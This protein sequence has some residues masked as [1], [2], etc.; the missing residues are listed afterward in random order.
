MS[1]MYSDIMEFCVEHGISLSQD[2]IANAK[3]A[4]NEDSVEDGA[5][6]VISAAGS[7]PKGKD[8]SQVLND[9][10]YG[11]D[12]DIRAGSVDPEDILGAIDS[13]SNGVDEFDNDDDDLTKAN[14][15]A[16][17]DQEFYGLLYDFMNENGIEIP[18]SAM[19]TFQ[20]AGV[21]DAG[22]NY[23][24]LLEF[25]VSNGISMDANQLADFEYRF[26]R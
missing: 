16:M 8:E 2:A 21:F 4:F 10:D 26:N 14:E 19:A 1:N 3:Y 17:S 6:K 15:S 24:N 13:A 23:T 9:I 25:C 5:Q 22:S 12:D 7:S 18:D 20:E 11:A